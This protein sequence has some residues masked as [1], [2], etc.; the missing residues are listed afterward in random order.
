MR[1]R[2]MVGTGLAGAVFAALIGISAPSAAPEKLARGVNCEGFT[3]TNETDDPYR[4]DAFVH[5]TE[6]TSTTGRA[7]IPPHGSAVIRFGCP[8]IAKPGIPAPPTLG[9]QP[10]GTYR[11]TQPQIPNTEHVLT[12]PVGVFYWNAEV[13]R[14]PPPTGSSGF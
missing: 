11:H 10:D 5:C 1:W 12:R 3:C 6:G 2:Q 13:D 9:R 8:T 4:V 14:T 7:W